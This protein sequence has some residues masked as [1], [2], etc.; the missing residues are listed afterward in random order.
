MRTSGA[1]GKS[2]ASRRTFRIIAQQQTSFSLIGPCCCKPTCPDCFPPSLLTRRRD[3]GRDSMRSRPQDEV[4][5]RSSMV[6]DVEHVAGGQPGGAARG[7]RPRPRVHVHGPATG[8][9]GVGEVEGRRDGLPGGHA[10]G[11]RD[12]VRVRWAARN[13]Q[14]LMPAGRRGGSRAGRRRASTYV[15]QAGTRCPGR[16]LEPCW[17]A[18]RRDARG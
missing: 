12:V 18:T 4:S 17:P 1:Q 3:G 8:A 10:P 2:S 16:R 15:T 13:G 7:R 9:D 14:S 5:R 11:R 6:Q